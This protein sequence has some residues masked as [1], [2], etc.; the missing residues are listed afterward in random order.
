M[1]EHLHHWNERGLIGLKC[2]TKNRRL[3]EVT[4]DVP[5]KSTPTTEHGFGRPRDKAESVESPRVEVNQPHGGCTNLVD[6]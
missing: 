1:A 3:P 2:R 5:V 4:V 6:L